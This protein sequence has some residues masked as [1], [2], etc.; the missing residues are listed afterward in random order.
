MRQKVVDNDTQLEG[1]GLQ[2]QRPLPPQSLRA[3]LVEAPQI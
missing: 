1:K 3:H 2:S